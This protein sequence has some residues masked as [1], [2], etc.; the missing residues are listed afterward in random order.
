MSQNYLDVHPNKIIL[1]RAFN[2][3]FYES[4]I[5]LTNTTNRYIVF[6][7]YINKSTQYSSNPSTGFIK[8]SDNIII[9]IKRVEK[10][11]FLKNRILFKIRVAKTNF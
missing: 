10:V 1:S 11:T 2:Q 8:P 4:K 5:T 3:S 9:T 7:V 6:K